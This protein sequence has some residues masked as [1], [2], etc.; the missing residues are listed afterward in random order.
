MKQYQDGRD[1]LDIKASTHVGLLGKSKE[2]QTYRWDELTYNSTY[3]IICIH[4]NTKTN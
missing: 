3:K 2:W 4:K 1:V